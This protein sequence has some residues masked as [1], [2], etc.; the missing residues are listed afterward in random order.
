MKEK[1]KRTHYVLLRIQRASYRFSEI[2]AM[3]VFLKVDTYV[4]TYVLE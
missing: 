2:S 4:C 1:P 3:A